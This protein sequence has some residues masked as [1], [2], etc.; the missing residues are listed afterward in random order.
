MS[1]QRA[2]A[3]RNNN[4]NSIVPVKYSE[5]LDELNIENAAIY[6][7]NISDLEY[8]GG[9]YYVDLAGNDSAGNPLNFDGRFRS[10]TGS[11]SEPEFELPIICFVVNIDTNPAF[12]P[13]KECTIFFK[14]IQSVEFGEGPPFLTIG[15]LDA[16]VLNGGEEGFPLPFVLSPPFP[17]L[18]GQ[19]ISPNI[20]FKSDRDNFDVV[21]S[22]PAGWLGLP[23]LAAILSVYES[24]PI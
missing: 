4:N 2:F 12:Y 15:L 5:S 13:G 10:L 11:E 19:N 20:T 1:I 6:T 17:P 16:S 21:S 18:S 14:N 23:A 22:G 9:I 8:V 7:L 24:I 3:Q